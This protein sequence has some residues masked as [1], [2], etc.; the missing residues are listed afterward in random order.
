M[1]MVCLRKAVMAHITTSDRRCVCCLVLLR[2]GRIDSLKA[3]L[4]RRSNALVI[5]GT[6]VPQP[7]LHPPGFQQISDKLDGLVAAVLVGMARISPAHACKRHYRPTGR[8][9]GAN[10]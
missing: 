7:A 5:G 6:I 10:S 1:D 3:K 8:S 2:T 9:R 4:A